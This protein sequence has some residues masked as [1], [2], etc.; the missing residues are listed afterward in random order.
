MIIGIDFDNTIACYSHA[1][2]QAAV[3]NCFIPKSLS[4]SKKTIRDFLRKNNQEDQWTKLQGLVYGSHMDL[5]SPYPGIEDFFAFA[6]QQ[7]I[8]IHIISHKTLYPY[9]GPKYNLHTSAQ[10]W[11]ET[12]SFYS[13]HLKVFFELTLEEKLKRIK[14]ENCTYFIDDLPEL[15][16]SENF[17]EDVQK[18]LFDPHNACETS[19]IYTKY[20]SWEQIRFFFE[21]L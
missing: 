12:Q 3:E 6:D 19:N 15:L 13:S 9:L 10:S 8:S 1:F 20:A 11:L 5:A 18:L 7:N 4:P 17:P 21:K 2:Y 14:S 16:A